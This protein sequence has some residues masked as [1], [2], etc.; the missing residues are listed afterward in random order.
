MMSTMNPG[1][2]ILDIFRFKHDH[3]HKTAHQSGD[4]KKFSVTIINP[5][6]FIKQMFHI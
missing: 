5:K 4:L 1:N 3:R 2:M 6:G